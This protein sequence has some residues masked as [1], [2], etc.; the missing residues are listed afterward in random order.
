MPSA[1]DAD[2][3]RHQQAEP[4]DAAYSGSCDRERVHLVRS[5]RA[6]PPV[7]DPVAAG[8]DACFPAPS[9][10]TAL[11]AFDAEELAVVDDDVV[12]VFLDPLLPP[13]R[14]RH[15]RLV[16]EAAVRVVESRLLLE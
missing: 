13:P 10:T 1:G 5:G 7:H 16:L 3:V 15:R 4:D 9:A 8:H 2:E 12:D 11:P 6:A 14:H